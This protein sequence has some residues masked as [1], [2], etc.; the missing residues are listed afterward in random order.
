M[1][2]EQAESCLILASELG[3]TEA[4]WEAMKLCKIST[5]VRMNLCSWEKAIPEIANVQKMASIVFCDDDFA[6]GIQET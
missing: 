6:D 4:A 1:D 2:F 5:Y 3:L